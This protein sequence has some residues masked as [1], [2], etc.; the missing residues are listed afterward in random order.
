MRFLVLS[1]QSPSFPHVSGGNPGEISSRRPIKAFG[2]DSFER[3]FSYIFF[4]SVQLVTGQFILSPKTETK[5]ELVRFSAK[6]A[7]PLPIL[8]FYFRHCENVVPSCSPAQRAM[9]GAA[10]E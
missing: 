1:N 4:D 8:F 10:L 9:P 2:G 6:S 5:S 3:Y 7:V